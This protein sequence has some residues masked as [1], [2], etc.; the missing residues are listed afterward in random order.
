MEQIKKK[1]LPP[2]CEHWL[3]KF[4]ASSDSKDIANFKQK[5]VIKG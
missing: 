3:I 2:Q 4:P 5:L 1:E